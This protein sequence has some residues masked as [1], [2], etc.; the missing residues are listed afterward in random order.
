MNRDDIAIAMDAKWRRQLG[1]RPAEWEKMDPERRRELLAYAEAAAE[2][3]WFP[4]AAMRFALGTA[5]LLLAC[6]IA[7]LIPGCA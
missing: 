4:L 3:F 1:Y 6:A 2:C 7:A 5:L